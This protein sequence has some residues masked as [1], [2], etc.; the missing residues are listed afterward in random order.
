MSRVLGS[1]DVVEQPRRLRFSR[2][3]GWQ[4]VRVWRGTKSACAAYAA[5]LAANRSVEDIDLVAAGAAHEVVAGYAGD[6]SGADAGGALNEVWEVVYEK[7]QKS[8][9]AADFM[10][11][12]GASRGDWVEK[13][14]KAIEAGTAAA[15]SADSGTPQQIKD[16]LDLRL[17]GTDSVTI[18]VPVVTQTISLATE[19]NVRASH[20]GVGQAWSTANI[21]APPTFL[22]QLPSG[23]EWLK[24]GP[25]IITV[26]RG[27]NLV[28]RWDGA[29]KWSKVLYNGTAVP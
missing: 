14:N 20:T 24:N 3:K 8:L 18:F 5:V 13:A 27:F 21:P 7:A 6:G 16:Y 28:Q 25:S 10:A 15:M 22:Y 4:Q 26:P 19:T 29:Q 2:Q 23:W 9:D 12:L 11:A 1:A 17:I